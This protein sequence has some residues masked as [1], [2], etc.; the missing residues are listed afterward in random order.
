MHGNVWEWCL[1]DYVDNYKDT[2]IDGSENHSQN[3]ETKKSFVAV[4]GTIILST[5]V[6][7]FAA[8]AILPVVATT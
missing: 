1:D 8:G 3:K 5:P 2:P 6:R 4:R 7:L